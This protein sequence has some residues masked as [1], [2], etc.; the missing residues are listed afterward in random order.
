MGQICLADHLDFDMFLLVMRAFLN[1]FFEAFSWPKPYSQQLRRKKNRWVGG[2][3]GAR[4]RVIEVFLAMAFSS[5]SGIMDMAENF[6]DSTSYSKDSINFG[7]IPGC[8]HHQ[9][10]YRR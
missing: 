8:L 6:W 3:F 10:K 7:V 4:F 5:I 9:H 2:P 1:A